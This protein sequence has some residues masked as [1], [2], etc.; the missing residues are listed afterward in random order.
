MTQQFLNVFLQNRT[1][2]VNY[3]HKIVECPYRAEDVV[4]EAFLRL[5]S[6]VNKRPLEQP[7][8]YLYRIV[9]N[10]ALDWKRR[11]KLE[12][13]YFDAN[14][15]VEQ[16]CEDRPSP[17]NITLHRQ[18]LE[19]VMEAISELPERHQTAINMHRLQG[20]KLKDIAKRLNISVASTHAL[21]FEAL[22][23]CRLRLAQKS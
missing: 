14:A 23:H 21:V 10:L 20:M 13:L 19:I 8:G 3:A 1:D 15:D 11:N 17:E 5:N 12:R 6:A 22:D 7:I 18:E 9:R 4:Q 16:R 2:L